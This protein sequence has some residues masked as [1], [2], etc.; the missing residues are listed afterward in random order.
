[1]KATQPS[2]SAQDTAIFGKAYFKQ[3]GEN[4]RGIITKTI[5]I[6]FTPSTAG[7]HNEPFPTT[8][9]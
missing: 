1:M 7:L 5:R 4:N 2:S 8:L 9:N 6:D 3:Y